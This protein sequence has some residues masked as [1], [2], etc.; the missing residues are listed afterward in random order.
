[1][2]KRKFNGG[3]RNAGRKK[4]IGISNDIKRYC[5]SFMVEM[6]K[7]DAIRLKAT[8]QIS[9]SLED[10]T[11]DFFYIIKN[12]E[13]YKLGFTSDIKKRMAN[14]KSHLGVVNL[15][16]VYEG[17]DSNDIETYLHKKYISK[18]VIGEYF[19]LSKQDII[20]IVSY[21]SFKIV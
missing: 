14:Y 21:C 1:M 13:N 10:E 11:P 8:K 3:H 16:Y 12:E 15:I 19:N 18:R 20:D 5:E 4:G 17:F 6:L 9:L 2:D 7:N